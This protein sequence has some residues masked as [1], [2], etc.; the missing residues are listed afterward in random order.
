MSLASINS[1][2]LNNRI[3]NL[4]LLFSEEYFRNVFPHERRYLGVDGLK[5]SYSDTKLSLRLAKDH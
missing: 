1:I 4:F 5:I 3:T 2:K